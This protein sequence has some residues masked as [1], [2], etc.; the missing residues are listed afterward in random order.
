[1]ELTDVIKLLKYKSL[2]TILQFI[3]ICLITVKHW[4]VSPVFD[5][6]K[7]ISIDNL[8]FI[9]HASFIWAIVYIAIGALVGLPL[10]IPRNKINNSSMR[11]GQD[12]WDVYSQDK[13]IIKLRNFLKFLSDKYPK[14][15]RY[16]FAKAD[17]YEDEL[18][19]LLLILIQL[20]YLFNNIYIYIF[21]GVFFIIIWYMGYVLG[22]LA[23]FK[24]EIMEALTK[25]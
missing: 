11:P 3:L 24:K 7:I 23:T 10:K 25:E 22:F 1:M 6:S 20:A 9:L 15:L 18:F 12:F 17:K 21:S 14:K 2:K 5:L 16:I 4:G 19:D 8:W 13:R